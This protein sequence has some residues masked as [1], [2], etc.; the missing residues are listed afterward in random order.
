MPK[1]RLRRVRFSKDAD[2]ALRTLKARTGITPNL[3]C[4]LALCLSLKEPG[5]PVPGQYPEDSDREINKPTLLGDYET[6]F[7]ALVVQRIFRDGLEATELDGQFRSHMHRGIT[8]LM[9]R[10]RSLSD[11]TSAFPEIPSASK[12]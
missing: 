1:L 3:L 8:T 9:G 5:V 11:I 6:L 12:Q 4:R 10:I 2:I 7:T